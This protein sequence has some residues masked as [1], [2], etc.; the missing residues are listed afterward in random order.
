VARLKR[1]AV[2]GRRRH[3]SILMR[4]QVN[5]PSTVRAVLR[6][7]RQRVAGKRW[8]VNAGTP[9]LRLRVPASARPGR[10]RLQLTVRGAFGHE[11]HIRRR[12]RLP[13]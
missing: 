3:R 2:I 1:T 11:A 5:A 9:L 10:Y 6:R 4:V 7:G 8:R 12:V 13:R